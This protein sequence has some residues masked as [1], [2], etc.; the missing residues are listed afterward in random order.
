VSSLPAVNAESRLFLPDYR[1][2]P[3]QKIDPPLIREGSLV[4]NLIQ[5]A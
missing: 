2:L 1:Y 5:T 4:V 3:R